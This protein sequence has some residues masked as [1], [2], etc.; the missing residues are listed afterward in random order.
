[1]FQSP[2][3]ISKVGVLTPLFCLVHPMILL[4]ATTTE[5]AESM[6]STIEQYL[7][8]VIRMF[9]ENPWLQGGAAI[10]VTLTVAS[11]VTWLLFKLIGTITS[12]TAMKL[13]GQIAT[14]LRPP[15]YYTFLVSGISYGLHRMP[16]SEVAQI[17][18]TRAVQSVGVLVWV[19]FFSRLASLL[20]TRFSQFSHKFSFIQHRTVTLFDNAAKVIIFA[21]G[22]YALFQIWKIDMT[23]WLAS[24]GIVGI[25]VGFAAKDTLANLFSGVFILADVPYKVGD[26]IVLDRG[27]RGMVTNIGLRSTRILT[28]DDVEIII[29]NSIIGNTTVINQSGGPSEKLRIRIKIGV[30]YGS[31]IDQV[32]SILLD[33][34][35]HEPLVSHTPEP[36]VRFRLFGASSLDFEL[37]CW[38][39]RPELRGR[40]KD[41]LN[42]AIYKSFDKEAIEIPYSKQDLYIRGLP[43]ALS[44]LS[45]LSPQ[46]DTTAHPPQS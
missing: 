38:I 4:A 22:L 8:P 15:I 45:S 19:L 36:R 1:M 44:S 21:L 28:R 12:R 30:A 35:E 20:L 9:G 23:A 37:L 24:A 7:Q 33:I 41:M 13:D 46:P 10:L 17:I 11:L 14:L 34:A 40:T 26:Y 2:S 39:S 18:F 6:A 16:L 3:C 31:D 29:P 5:S 27:D 25:A 32:R 42:D 43:E